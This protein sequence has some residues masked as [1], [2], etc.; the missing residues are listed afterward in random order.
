VGKIITDLRQSVLL[1][2]ENHEKVAV[3]LIRFSR[4]C[5]DHA[6]GYFEG[7]FDNLQL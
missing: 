4:L 1:V 7:G 6:I 3:A 2:A 5:Y